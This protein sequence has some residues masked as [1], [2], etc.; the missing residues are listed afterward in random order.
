MRRVIPRP[1]RDRI[2]AACARLLLAACALALAQPPVAQAHGGDGKR[3]PP[4]LATGVAFSPAGELWIVGLDR[5]RRLFVQSSADSGR[6]WRAPRLIDTGKDRIAADGEKGPNLVF[7]PDDQ[8]VITYSSPYFKPQTGQVRLLRSG[9]GGRSFAPPVTVHQ[10]RQLVSHLFESVAFDAQGRLH[11]LWVDGRDRERAVKAALAAAPPVDPRSGRATQARPIAAVDYRGLA[12]YRNESGDGGRTFGPDIMLAEHSCE[13]C[14]I[15]LAPTPEG[16]LAA[17]WRHVFEPNERDHA[18][19]KLGAAREAAPVRASL[20]HWA[21]DACPHQGPGLAPASGG[22]YHAIW[23]GSRAGALRV[24]YGRLD[25]E[26]LPVGEARAVPDERAEHAS[27]AAAGPR[28]A[29]S[30]N[31]FDGKTTRWRAWVSADEGRSFVLR[32]LGSAAED[33]DH[34]RLATR[35]EEIFALWRTAQGVRVERLA[36]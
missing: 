6:S 36:P 27:L 29:I 11:T 5:E 31:S 33:S 21:L 10:D 2:G 35:G 7:G 8:V 28:V 24:R 12:I 16:S 23:F 32:E 25:A 19:V 17:M 22:G 18:F 9:D 3:R 1:V 4:A 26:G 14:S 30:W 20:D 34:A 15:A 13:C